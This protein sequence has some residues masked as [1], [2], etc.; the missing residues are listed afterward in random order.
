M[1]K[2]AAILVGLLPLTACSDSTNKLG[3]EQKEKSMSQVGYRVSEDFKHQLAEVLG[4]NP[5][6][7]RGIRTLLKRAG[8]N[9]AG[10]TAVAFDEYNRVLVYYGK[11]EEHRKLKKLIDEIDRKFNSH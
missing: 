3:M 7:H 6:N 10:E 9:F 4:E 8:I 11:E 1:S 2:T 5:D